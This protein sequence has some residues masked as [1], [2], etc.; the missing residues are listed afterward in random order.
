MAATEN[1]PPI[2]QVAGKK[3][4]IEA[5]FDAIAPRYDV[6][7][8]LMSL[9]IDR[10]WRRQA[11]AWL[12]PHHPKRILDVATGTADLAVEALRLQPEHIIG[13]D[14]S[15]E[16]LAIGREKLAQRGLDNQITLERGDSEKLPFEAHQFDAALV[17]FG[18]RNFEDLQQGLQEIRRVLRPE[19]PLVVLELS[20]P[21]TF[22]FKQLYHL[23]TRT[24]LPAMGRFISKDQGAYTYLPASIGQFP[25][26]AAFEAELENAGFHT[27]QSRPLTFGAASLYKGLA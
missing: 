12:K 13:V 27:V 6:L 15:E 26:G 8:R 20:E 21:R 1:R 4:A 24:L 18:V 22:P 3:V 17:A 14:L 11:V 10:R 23:Y 25:D 5:M 9:G 19:A 2:G 7:N 16:M